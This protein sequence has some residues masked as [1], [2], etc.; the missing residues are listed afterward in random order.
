MDEC[1][2]LHPDVWTT[3]CRP[4]LADSGGHALFIG[5][6]KGKC[7]WFYDLF[8]RSGAEQ[9]WNSHSYR[10]I[11]GG[12][13]TEEEIESAKR[14]LAEREFRQE[15]LAEFQDYS[16][17]IYHSFD[18]DNIQ[19]NEFPVEQIRTLHIGMDFNVDPMSA[20]VGQ[21]EKDKVYFVD[22]VIIY[23]SNTDE[24]VQELRDRYGTKIPIFI[25]PDPASKQRKTSAGGRTDLSILQNA[26]FKVK[27]KH[28]HPSIRDRVNAVNAKLKD[29]KGTRHIFVSKS[30]KTM[31]KVQIIILKSI[32][33]DIFSR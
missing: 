4:M 18:E 29:S 19:P 5:T 30:C 26:G 24:M 10:T 12:W 11:D 8:V 31:I 32:A 33:K 27:V 22:E 15:F 14:D 25:Y 2:D 9:Q 17:V 16:G 28:K 20:C 3:I 21:I 6:P 23:G 1:A 7:N 13:V